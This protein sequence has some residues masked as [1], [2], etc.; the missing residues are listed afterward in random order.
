M[1]EKNNEYRQQ[2][3]GIDVPA[4]SPKLEF[5]DSLRLKLFNLN[6]LRYFSDSLIYIQLRAWGE[7]LGKNSIGNKE[8]A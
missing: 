8:I 5:A 3:L 1:T 4:K 2:E 7:L 6:D